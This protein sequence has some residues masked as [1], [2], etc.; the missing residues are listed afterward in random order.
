MSDSEENAID[1]DDLL[2][3][4]YGIGI[5]ESV[6]PNILSGLSPPKFIFNL[7]SVDYIKV[8]QK[9]LFYSKVEAKAK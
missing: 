7:A 2:E 9:S 4:C 3:E 8:M 5:E 6:L 1:D